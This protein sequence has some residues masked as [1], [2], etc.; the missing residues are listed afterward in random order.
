MNLQEKQIQKLDQ[1]ILQLNGDTT[2]KH[3]IEKINLLLTN[4]IQVNAH[5]A[6]TNSPDALVA[7]VP[8]SGNTNDSVGLELVNDENLTNTKIDLSKNESAKINYDLIEM[9]LIELRK[10]IA[11]S[12]FNWNTKMAEFFKKSKF[13]DDEDFAAI[14]KQL[15]EDDTPQGKFNLL[16]RLVQILNPT[17]AFLGFLKIKL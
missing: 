15:K 16:K 6:N 10:F 5:S 17:K 7:A 3:K 11:T 4:Q 8:F 12:T 2:L 9:F 1:Y 14:A 13:D